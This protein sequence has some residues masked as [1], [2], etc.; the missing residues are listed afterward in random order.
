VAGPCSALQ[1]MS[2][3]AFA[4]GRS[5]QVKRP[6]EEEHEDAPA[7]MEMAAH[8]H[9]PLEYVNLIVKHPTPAAAHYGAVVHFRKKLVTQLKRV[10]SRL[11]HD[12]IFANFSSHDPCSSSILFARVKLNLWNL[13]LF[14]TNFSILDNDAYYYWLRA[15]CIGR[16]SLRAG[17]CSKAK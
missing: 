15:C 11:L 14:G 13:A 7:S 4:S 5:F 12:V 16:S 9:L 2:R 1:T 3:R 8:A 6:R 17:S 10:R